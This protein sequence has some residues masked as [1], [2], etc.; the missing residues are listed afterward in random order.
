MTGEKAMDK[1][2]RA[3]NII[4][5][6]EKQAPEESFVPVSISKIKEGLEAQR[7]IERDKAEAEA[8]RADQDDGFGDFGG[9]GG[10]DDFGGDFGGGEDDL[11]G[12]D[13]LG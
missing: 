5:F 6:L 10:G 8:A 12:G 4:V 11:G 13:F 1:S 9:F 3:T 7:K 2:S